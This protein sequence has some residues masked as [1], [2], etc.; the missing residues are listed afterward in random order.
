MARVTVE[1][2]ICGFLTTIEAGMEGRRDVK[3]AI[4]TKCPNLAPLK[5]ELTVVDGR[6]E[7]FA[8]LGES[9]IYQVSQK[10]CKHAACPVPSAI[11]KAVE[12]ACQMALPKDVH[13][14]I[15]K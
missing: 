2:G 8:R 7:C 9:Q 4:E 11:H 1:P 3:L 5:E 14:T 6:N 10:Y 12:V 15:S 13:M